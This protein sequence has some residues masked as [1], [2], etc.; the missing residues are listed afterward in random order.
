MSVSRQTP[1]LP[2]KEN[3]LF[4]DLVAHYETKKYKK[5]LK[6]A[7][8]ILKKF[9]EHGETLAMKGLTI[10]CMGADKKEH[11]YEL[12]RAGIKHAIRSHVC[13]HVY[14]LL[15]RGDHNYNE[16]IKCYRNALRNDK[17]NLQ[18][19]RDLS[20]LQIHMRDVEGF[21]ETRRQLL[22]QKPVNKGHWL[23][24]AMGAHLRKDYGGA[25][26]ILGNYEKSVTPSKEPDM[27]EKNEL[28][29]YYLYKV[30]VLEESG[31]FET[32][33]KE[34]LL[35]ANERRILDKLDIKETQARLL[36]QL[37]RTSEAEGLYKA[38]LKTNP[39][40]HEYYRQLER[41][42]GVRH[43]S[44][45]DNGP[46]DTRQQAAAA[47]LYD[48]LQKEFPRA[49]A[50]KRIPLD[51]LDGE[52]F[53]TRLNAYAKPK[54]V[55]GVPSLFSDLDSLY[56]SQDKVNVIEELFGSYVK[57]LKQDRAF[58]DTTDKRESPAAL[59]WTLFFYAQHFD[60]CGKTKL[61]LQYIDEAIAHT[62]TA[63]ELY[64]AKAR[65]YKHAGD[66][67]QAAQLTETARQMDLADRCLANRSVQYLLRNGDIDEAI[68]V[69]GLFTKE[70]EDPT[71]NLDEMQCNWFQ[72]AS[73]KA[74]LKQGKYGR[75]L[76]KLLSIEKHFKDF[77]EDQFD[78]HS[79][80]LRKFTLRA[81]VRMLRFVDNLHA[82]P[83]FA[84]AAKLIIRAYLDLYDNPS[85]KLDKQH[86][87]ELD[88]LSAEERRKAERK[89]KKQELASKSKEGDKEKDKEKDKSAKPVDE[90]PEGKLLLAADPLVEAGRFVETLRRQ[91]PRDLDTLVLAAEY[92]LRKKKYLLVLQSLKRAASVDASS[93]SLHIVKARFFTEVQ[94]NLGSLNPTVKQVFE[95]ESSS[96]LGGLS[97]SD[98]NAAYL[99]QHASSL[100]HRAAAA[101]VLAASSPTE[102]LSVLRVLDSSVVH[103]SEDFKAVESNLRLI[104]TRFGAEP[105][106]EYRRVAHQYFPYAIAFAESRPSAEGLTAAV[107]KLAF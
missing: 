37:G 77:V 89:A 58:P 12:V 71:A 44:A 21:W 41:A 107:E 91:L 83:F 55:K 104:Q 96:L 66:L 63:I 26:S 35:H 67:A 54:L 103:G 48:D 76:K 80:C 6:C 69:V 23:A 87:P 64:S 38:L 17:D 92:Y 24:Y 65:I 2:P 78:F 88:G 98:Y 81:Y 106:A 29:E 94:A 74:Y 33:L 79:Y 60:K 62:P 42:A 7:D 47:D 56:R 43:L 36:L 45:L 9:P 61:A 10:S 34:L 86:N 105:A 90:D 13:W 1:T 95:S 101:E 46:L 52:A 85:L 102:A 97:L 14:G 27:N 50:P 28:S 72:Y 100:P 3:S 25:L 93:P 20:V 53:R 59:L 30:S 18:I 16:A 4:K 31:D 68:R 32:A 75:A 11:A 99:K 5:G 82:H 51:L 15:Y 57:S 40:Q 73:G 84:R 22:L 19:L 49:D 8:A 70:G 39:E